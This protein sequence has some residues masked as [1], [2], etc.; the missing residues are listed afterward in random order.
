MTKQT[1][2]AS[3]PLMTFLEYV[4]SIVFVSTSVSLIGLWAVL[5]EGIKLNLFS[6]PWHQAQCRLLLNHCLKHDAKMYG[7]DNI[8][9]SEHRKIDMGLN[10]NR[11]LH[12]EEELEVA[13]EGSGS[14]L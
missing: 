12:E 9:V 14:I 10:A 5:K 1:T 13:L 2:L 4:I 7:I 8:G 3:V 11:K 6:L